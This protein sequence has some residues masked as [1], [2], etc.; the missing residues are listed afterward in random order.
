[1][2]LTQL[3]YVLAVNKHR[4]FGKAAKACFVTQP[5]L[6]MQVQKLEEELGVIVFDRSKSTVL[7]TSEG[8]TVIEQAKAS[9]LT[10]SGRCTKAKG[11]TTRRWR[12]TCKP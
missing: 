8:E 3:E 10:T 5:T 11:C 12:T 4:H 1:M 7:P 6:S 9:T 2:T